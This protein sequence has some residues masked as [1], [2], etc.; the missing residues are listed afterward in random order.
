MECG[1][2]QRV[3]GDDQTWPDGMAEGAV[4]PGK[5][6][7]AG[8]GKG[9][10]FRINAES[11]EDRRLG[12]LSTPASVRKLQRALHVKA[13]AE[14]EFRFY[15]LYDKLYR[16]DILLYAYNRC[17]ANKGSTGVDGQTFD[18][19]EQL[20]VQAWLVELEQSLRKQTYRPDPIKRVYIP[21]PN[22][23]LR[24][25]GLSILRDRVCMMTAVP[26]LEPI[27]DAK[28]SLLLAKSCNNLSFRSNLG[29]NLRNGAVLRHSERERQ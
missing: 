28:G 7:N 12:N 19:I 21:K 17:R 24:P 5:P 1:I 13:K 26:V 15:A 6:G 3:I 4:V 8:G 29:Q 14:P 27:F 20:G 18:D 9:P 11:S 23:K 10:W 16:E 22:G 2:L 25:L